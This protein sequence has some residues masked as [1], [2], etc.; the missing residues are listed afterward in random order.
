LNIDGTGPGWADSSDGIRKITANP[1]PREIPSL[2]SG[3]ILQLKE[4]EIISSLNV[5]LA[6]GTVISPSDL[7]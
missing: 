4:A 3:S 6:T 1:E 5:P 7:T 2:V